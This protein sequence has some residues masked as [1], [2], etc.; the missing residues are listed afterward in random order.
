[1][2]N[3]QIKFHYHSAQRPDDSYLW[4]WKA[5]VCAQRVLGEAFPDFRA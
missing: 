2:E 4:E 1:M 3:S 5:A